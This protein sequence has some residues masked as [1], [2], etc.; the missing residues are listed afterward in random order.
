L[1]DI[2]LASTEYFKFTTR[3]FATGI[4]TTL[5][6]SPVISAYED[7]S[8]TQ[9][10]AGITLGVDHDS[11]TGLNLITV[12]ATGA[13]GFEAGKHYSLV[14]TTGTVGGVS[15]VG[16]IVDEFTVE[17]GAAYGVVNN[18]TY[19][20][21]Q[22]VRATTPANTFNVDA[23]NRGEVLL[24]AV[25]HTGATV[26]NVTLV[27]TTTTNSDMRGT[28][29]AA[30][31][32][33]ATEARLAELDAANLPADIDS[34]LDDTGTSGVQVADKAGYSLS[35]TGLDL[36]VS[37]ATGMV[38]IAKAVWDR[39]IS[40]ANHNIAQSAGKILRQSGG[41]LFADGTAQAGTSSTIQLAVGAVTYDG[42]FV[43]AKVITVGGTGADQEAIITGSTALTDTLDIAPAW[44]VTPDATTDYQII[45]AQVH[46]TIRDGGYDGGYVYLNVTTG[47]AGVVPGISGTT[48]EPSSVIADART[49]ADNENLR[50]FDIKGGGS[51][52]LDQSYIDW[53]FAIT[54][55]HTLQLNNQDIARSAIL[56][57]GISGTT[58]STDRF[59]LKECALFGPT[60]S[61]CTLLDC[62]FG[63][64]TTLTSEDTYYIFEGRD[65]N[66]LAA[67][68]II[69]VQGNG[70]TPTRV[71]MLSYHGRVEIQNMTSVDE[72][73]ITGNAKVTLNVNNTGGALT[74]SGDIKITDNSGNVT[75][76]NG[77]IADVEARTPTVAQL[78]YLTS[79]S[80]DGVPVTFS[81]GTTTTAV[82]VNVDGSA[83][84][85]VNDYYNGRILI[86]NSGTLQ[87]QATDITDYDGGTKTATITSV[88]TAITGSHTANMK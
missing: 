41:V 30:L 39:V 53:V 65:L 13:N 31:A 78:A 32:S 9:I 49:I 45:P 79:N 29:N 71:H 52:I 26:P 22:L 82:L 6:G 34:I 24:G 27:A 58:A 21:A 1:R 7:N 54:G 83:A 44:S 62:A 57:A 85:S 40:K 11:V 12:V 46:S 19:G 68:P 72:V 48:T 33:V 37:T 23:N 36:I 60:L 50:Q 84:S 88:T 75:I 20:N 18:G 70:V 56:Q 80:A 69:D 51:F 81:G 3:A 16:E 17:S 4:P 47:S 64:T 87:H 10:T 38:A 73:I 66:P 14:V 55:P 59:I 2:T 76:T 43:R 5:A 67:A 63:L 15:V 28:D 74:R 77:V 86:F 8:I 42:Q 25:T 35:A 61:V